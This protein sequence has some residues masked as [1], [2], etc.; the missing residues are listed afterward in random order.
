MKNKLG[1]IYSNAVNNS[2]KQK[3]TLNIYCNAKKGKSQTIRIKS[4]QAM[5]ECS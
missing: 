4:L 5:N 2:P 3:T 1:L